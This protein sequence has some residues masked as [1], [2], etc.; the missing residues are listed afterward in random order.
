MKTHSDP[1][2]DINRL[3]YTFMGMGIDPEKAGKMVAIQME[4]SEDAVLEALKLY[5]LALLE[6]YKEVQ[7]R[8][9]GEKPTDAS[10]WGDWIRRIYEKCDN[11]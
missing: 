8:I 1:I 6:R 4:C 5:A 11:N 9:I 2:T 7:K 3:F 10:T